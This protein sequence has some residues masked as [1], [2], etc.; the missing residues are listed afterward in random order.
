MI[1]ERLGGVLFANQTIKDVDLY[2][3]R[4]TVTTEYMIYPEEL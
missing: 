1:C 2:G 3:G 4:I